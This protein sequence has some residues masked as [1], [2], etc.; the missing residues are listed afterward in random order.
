MKFELF[1]K[2]AADA[3]PIGLG[4]LAVGFSV[5]I[6]CR[7]VGL[8]AFEGFLIGFLNNASAGEYAGLTVI[9]ADGGFMGMVLMMLVANARYMLMSAALSQ[10][11]SPDMPL[12]K[13]MIIGFD[14]TDEMFGLAIAQKGYLS[15]AYFAGGMSVVLPT[16]CGGTVLGIILGDLMPA[17]LAEGFS[18]MLFGMFIAIIIP[19]G[20]K[21]KVVLGCI[22]VGFA[23][24]LAFR[25]I[26]LLNGIS[27]G[28]VTIILTVAISTAAALLFPRN[29][30][31]Q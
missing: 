10:H 3:V 4:Y 30:E 1:R 11:I 13:R 12:W 17:W 8:N 5:G 31:E 21:D 24:S 15:F 19:A 16:W 7:N 28:T 25:L 9:A 23:L 18:V 6:A 14:I 22:G 20:K 27:S 29:E 26:P 2:G